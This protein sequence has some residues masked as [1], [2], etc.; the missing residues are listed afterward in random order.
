MPTEVRLA[1]VGLGNIGQVH[2]AKIMESES[3]RLVAVSDPTAK[4]D[5]LAAGLGVP[6]RTDYRDLVAD[7]PEGVVVAVPNALHR[8]IAVFFASSGVHLLVEKPLAESAAAGRTIVAAARDGGVELLVGHHRRHNNLVPAA[9]RLVRERIGILLATNSLLTLRK[10]DSYYDEAWRR[11]PEAG[12]LLVNVIHEIDNLRTICGEISAVQSSGSSLARGFE[13]D[14]TLAIVLRYESGAVG[15]MTVS[16]STPSPWSWE[17][18]V[19]EGLGFSRYGQD[20]TVILGTEG[21]L[22]FPSLRLWHFQDAE[23]PGWSSQLTTTDFGVDPNDPYLD[24]IED[25][26]R[27]IRGLTAPVVEGSDALRSLAVIEAINEAGVTGSTVTV[28]TAPT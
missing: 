21:S 27:V 24:Q 16:E 15:T 14:D 1:V 17:A 19:G 6:N 20:N 10:P 26:A 23:E 4:G 11:G 9:R 22:S 2:L 12:P 7:R 5:E 25:F 13:F 3:A 28:E 18:S 8:E